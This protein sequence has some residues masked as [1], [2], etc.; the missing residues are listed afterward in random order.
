MFKKTKKIIVSFILIISIICLFTFPAFASTYS[1]SHD[2]IL[3][4]NT[5]LIVSNGVNYSKKY[6]PSLCNNYDGYT[7]NHWTIKDYNPPS[8]STS[9]HIYLRLT[10]LNGI[11]VPKG[12]R[13][14]IKFDMEYTGTLLTNRDTE[15]YLNT[16]LVLKDIT[17]TPRQNFGVLPINTRTEATFIWDNTI[18][19]TTID[20]LDI[21]LTS[22]DVFTINNDF[23]FET[24]Y[25]N[26]TVDVS[27]IP[28]GAQDIID[29]QNENTDK[30]IKHDEEMR[31][32]EKEETKETGE[33]SVDDVSSAIP[34]DNDGFISALE[35]LSS[36]LVSS[37]TTAKWTF[38]RVYLPAISGIMEEKE[39]ITETQIDFNFWVNKIP[40]NILSLIR[41]LSTIALIIFCFKELYDT[42]SYILTMRKGVEE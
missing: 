12:Q 9:T 39:L 29:N 13:V 25:G 40:S 31:E 19:D 41:V 14:T 3:T 1:Y 38:P 5:K 15:L 10:E 2:K 23:Y 24:L 30:L 42:I 37:S 8:N 6:T 11:Y 34:S 33:G 22:Y 16:R 18:K 36:S 4:E 28:V 17:S 35:K 27:D 32:Q 7:T 21:T 20:L 26:L